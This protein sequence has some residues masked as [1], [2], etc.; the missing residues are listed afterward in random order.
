MTPMST[1]TV[2][3]GSP[4][5][6]VSRQRGLSAILRDL[7]RQY[8][9]VDRSDLAP[10]V[11]WGDAATKPIHR[12]LK[13]REAYSPEL[14]EKLSLGQR[15]LDPFC[16]CG[17]IMVGAA[18]LSR[19][20]F[21]LDVNPLATFAAQVKVRPLSS[22]Q[23]AKISRFA[24]SFRHHI[25]SIKEWPT[26]GLS[27]A[28]KVF[29]PAIL[30]TLMKLRQL[31]DNEHQRDSEIGDF[32]LLAWIAIL[33]P[34]G[35]YFK[36][37][38]GIKYR[39]KKRRPGRYEDRPDGVWQQRRFGSD[40]RAFVLRAFERQLEMMLD[41][42]PEWSDGR[43]A[44][45]TVQREDALQAAKAAGRRRFD[46]IVFSPPYANRFDYFE[47]LKVELWFGG[48]V[49]TYD[50]LRALRKS[51]L[52]SH[53]GADLQR[54]AQPLDALEELINLMDRDASSWRMG[55]AELLRGYFDDML[56]VLRQ[57]RALAPDGDCHVVV[58]NS[59]FAGVIIPTDLLIAQLGIE[60]GF[61]EVEVQDVRHLTVSPQQRT[62]L[63]GH[64]NHMRESIVSFR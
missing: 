7:S 47:S 27:I 17:S 31:I 2:G 60:A 38:N 10:F 6:N 14:I 29:E 32:L 63:N 36:E 45:Q 58:G 35:S 55:V 51:S 30:E 54:P 28:G 26:P 33:E 46:S 61:E 9:F 53:L 44:D 49:R 5:Q 19:R 37:G 11:H 21:G 18:K 56:T 39:N 42:V 20:S 8:R 25:P 4:K 41:D 15:I 52:R 57:C 50:D 48:F 12:W 13:Y 3:T 16:G 62:L 43:W 59:A 23:I 64:V 22:R 24:E 40:Q 1:C 34:V